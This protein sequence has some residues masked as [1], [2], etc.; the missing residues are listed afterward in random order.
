MLGVDT[1]LFSNEYREK[2]L[3]ISIKYPNEW[4]FIDQHKDEKFEGVVFI[5]GG[6]NIDFG[7]TP[8]ISLYLKDKNYFLS[9][10]Y[11]YSVLTDFYTAYYNDEI[12]IGSQKIFEIYLRTN[13]EFDFL[14]KLQAPNN[15]EFEE[16]KHKFFFMLKSFKYRKGIF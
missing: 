1:S 8:F 4:Y 12:V 2:S 11:K 3:N 10:N 9:S 15:A 6:A 7:N 13:D 14:F 5:Y 16:Y